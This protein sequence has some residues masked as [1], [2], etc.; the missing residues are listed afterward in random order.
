MANREDVLNDFTVEEEMSPAILKA[1]LQRYPEFTS[2]LLAL[3]N[4]LSMSDLASAEAS[5]PLE[6][7]SVS[8]EALRVL[9]VRQ[10]LFG[11]G[12]REFA[13]DVGLPRAFFTGLNAEVI[14]I[15]SMPTSLLKTLAN[16]LGVHM[17]D[18]ISGMQQG[19]GQAVAM[20]SDVKPSAVPAIEFRDYVDCAGLTEEEQRVLQSLLS[21]DGSD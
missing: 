7:K 9:H 5:L 15:A 16:R 13:R 4:E 21:D 2:D 10:S 8:A 1:Y 19:D 18:V 17:Q 6:T 20:K 14:H 11:T 3:F 12:V